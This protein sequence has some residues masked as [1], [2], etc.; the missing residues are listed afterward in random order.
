MN[1]KYQKI[2][3]ERSKNNN[4]SNKMGLKTV[5]IEEGYAKTELELTDDHFNLIKSVHG[6]CL[7]TM[8]DTT[9]GTAAY[10]WGGSF[11]TINASFNFLRP[12]LTTNSKKLICEAESIK[13]G[14]N[15]SV[16]HVVIKNDKDTVIAD[17]V[18]TYHSIPYE[19]KL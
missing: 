15:V 13:H 1:P 18:F 6:G 14:K 19:V 5:E 7:F 4:F 2:F 17:G 11:V 3:D 12:A 9:G 16:S 10:S 8:A